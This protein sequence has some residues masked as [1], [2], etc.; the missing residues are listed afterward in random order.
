MKTLNIENP[1][2]ELEGIMPLLFEVLSIHLNSRDRESIKLKIIEKDIKSQTNFE[3]TINSCYIL[4]S[5]Y[6][7]KLEDFKN[8]KIDLSLLRVVVSKECI[9]IYFK[10]DINYSNLKILYTDIKTS[11]IDFNNLSETNKQDY[12]INRLIDTLEKK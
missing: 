9:D 7:N 1:F 2:I 10:D 11:I 4:L 12:F 8:D 3:K 5:D 6:I